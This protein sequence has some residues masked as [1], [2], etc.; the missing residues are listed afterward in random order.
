MFPRQGGRPRAGRR[1]A[2]LAWAPT[3]AYWVEEG[4]E[5]PGVQWPDNWEVCGYSHP[6]PTAIREEDKRPGNIC[7]TMP[8]YHV[9]DPIEE[10]Q[11][12]CS[13]LEQMPEPEME[14]WLALP[15]RQLTFGCGDP[16][17]DAADMNTRGFQIPG[18]VIA[19]MRRLQLRVM[20]GI[21]P[22]A[23]VIGN[24]IY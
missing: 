1:V 12:I 4:A 18:A 13:F 9:L 11:H 14:R 15:D 21:H 7:L 20:I 17:M 8:M 2:Q 10:L 22:A 19:R 16:E 24:L 6:N 23:K 5:H 3:L